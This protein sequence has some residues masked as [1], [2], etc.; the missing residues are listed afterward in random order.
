[1]RPFRWALLAVLLPAALSAQARG[2]E[3]RFLDTTCAPCRDFYRYANGAWLDTAT[4]APAYN[5]VGVRR[6]M[7]SQV[8]SALRR[9]LEAAAGTAA[10]TDGAD[11]RLG[12]FYATCMD[13]ARADRL[14]SA[15][16]APQLRRISAIRTRGDLLAALVYL[17]ER[18][19][20]VPFS[21]GPEPDPAA[22]TRYIGQLYQAGLGLPDRDYYL[23]ADTESV[24]LRREYPAHIGRMF[25]LIGVPARQAD[26]DA[27][28]VAEFETGL[29]RA[30]L[31]LV[32]Q[33]N[34]DSVY[35]PMPVRELQ[36]RAPGLDWL[37]FFGRLGV[38][39]P[40]SPDDSLDVSTPAFMTHVAA[41]F[42]SAPLATWR[43]YLRW[44][45]TDALADRLGTRLAREHF[46][47]QRRFS[48]AT[49]QV[50]RWRECAEDADQMLPDLLGKA[51]T[52][53]EVSP[54]TRRRAETMVENIRAAFRQRIDRL[55][56]MNPATRAAA[57][58]KLDGMHTHVAAPDRW[59]DYPGLEVSRSASY[60]A[61]L[62]AAT[63]VEARRQFARIGRPVDRDEWQAG[64]MTVDAF[65][66]P[67][68]NGIFIL[69]GML[70]LPRFDAG[71]DDAVNYGSLGSLIGH[72]FTHGFDDQGRRYDATGNL[73]DWWTGDDAR[74][75]DQLAR[76]VVEQYRAYIAI[77]SLHVNGEFTLGE[78][79]GDLGGIA[80]A[81]DAFQRA[82]AGK[83]GAPI[84]GFTPA[85]RFF[86]AYAQGWR[87]LYRPEARRTR[88]L[89]DP[90]APPNWRINGSLANLPA[91]AEAFG[92]RA[93]D[94]MVRPPE[95]ATTVW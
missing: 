90:H 66:N 4:F 49:A 10:T 63:A 26:E 1:M 28:L 95:L 44:R 73:R 82:Q 47:F 88:V 50:P 62:L 5:N 78:N 89:T 23:R 68:V 92:C 29:A 70:Q 43:A 58:E 46:G 7:E 12:A 75:F 54:D 34:P 21:F 25:R 6:D 60:P 20:P 72:E 77:D 56:W 16:I 17:H 80:I 74:R 13:S 14:E 81:W 85:Q 18:A 27:R 87:R 45:L 22:A 51:Y 8:D 3:R 76:R 94:P 40:R 30:S 93:G 86:L 19:I 71:A 55:A 37:A 61:N 35:H 64:P 42:A 15:A 36:A 57:R 69:P 79:I 67:P 52:R 24:A 31:S 65:Y 48:G 9:I 91:F 53:A 32:A 83:P 33:R 84:D 59:R 39:S 41:R 11:Q 2:F 38:A